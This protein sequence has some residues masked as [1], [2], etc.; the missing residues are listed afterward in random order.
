[1]HHKYSRFGLGRSIWLLQCALLIMISMPVR[2]EDILDASL[3]EQVVMIP[4]KILFFTIHLETTIFKP[5]GDGPF[6]LVVL[7]HGKN[8]GNAHMQARWR[9]I[10][11]V[12][13][14]VERGYVVA[15]PMRTGFSKSG[16]TAIET[17]CNVESDGDLQAEDVAAA[18]DYLT[19]LPYIDAHKIVIMGQSH[20]GLATVAFGTLNYPGVLGLVDFAGGLFYDYCGSW[21]RNQIRAFGHYGA[22][23][24]IPSLWFYGDND[25][26]WHVPLPQQ[27][28]ERY[29]AEGGHARWVDFGIFPSGDAHFMFVSKAGFAIWIPEIAKF[30]TELGLTFPLQVPPKYPQPPA[31]GF[32]QLTDIQALPV[33]ASLRDN[34]HASYEKF[35]AGSLPRAFV[36]SPD[37]QNF[38]WSAQDPAALDTAMDSC[39]SQAHSLCQFYAI[40]NDVVWNSR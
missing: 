28:Y 25:S 15:L 39:K 31:S 13:Q 40:D 30:F 21:A 8:P 9:A 12:R 17:H 10:A 36:I 1:M 37:G 23:T 35:L 3:N 5:P 27:M 20:G 26:Y 2:A 32:A 16:G 19:Q 14:F 24:K 6:P 34:A 7:N 4:K 22:R 29:N 38:A 33:P 18:L 11:Q